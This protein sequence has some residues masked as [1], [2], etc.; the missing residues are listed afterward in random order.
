[1]RIETL[2]KLRSD[3][4]NINYLRENSY[5]Y[6]YLNRSD[7]YFKE[8]EEEMK[9]RYKITPEERLKKMKDAVESVSKIIDILN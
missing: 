3:I 8:F 5:W 7:A 9:E 4:N 2:I 1:M 6:K